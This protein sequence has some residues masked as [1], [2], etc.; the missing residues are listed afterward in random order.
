[1]KILIFFGQD[2]GFYLDFLDGDE[3]NSGFIEKKCELH[4]V[5]KVENELRGPLN[6]G[7]CSAMCGYSG[8]LRQS[9]IGSGLYSGFACP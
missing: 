2:R 7:I 5:N 3:P 8:A 4:Q 6:R 9:V 1:M